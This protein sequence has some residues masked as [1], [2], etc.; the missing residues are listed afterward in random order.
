M[1]PSS[2]P[3][4]H[5]DQ[6]V[7]PWQNPVVSEMLPPELHFV[8]TSLARPRSVLPSA[9]RRLHATCTT[10]Q[11]IHIAWRNALLLWADASDSDRHAASE[12]PQ[13]S[14]LISATL[15]HLLIVNLTAQ[16][17]SNFAPTC[18]NPDPILTTRFL[19]W[20]F[21]KPFK[22][23]PSL[24]HPPARTQDAL[25]SHVSWWQPSR[26]KFTLLVYFIRAGQL[27]LLEECLVQMRKVPAPR[28]P[29][30]FWVSQQHNFD[31]RPGSHQLLSELAKTHHNDHAPFFMG[32]VALALVE[33]SLPTLLVLLRVFKDD[34][35]P[36][37]VTSLIPD[38]S[39]TQQD[40]LEMLCCL[41]PPDNPNRVI[42]LFH[43]LCATGLSFTDAYPITQYL[44]RPSLPG[45]FARLLA[46]IDLPRL[47]AISD[48][49]RASQFREKLG[50]ATVIH[51]K[52]QY[53]Q[54]LFDGALQHGLFEDHHW[55]VLLSSNVDFWLQT[56]QVHVTEASAQIMVLLYAIR[57][58]AE[59][60]YPPH[61]PDTVPKLVPILQRS[62]GIDL[63]NMIRRN[64]DCF[65][66]S[67]GAQGVLALHGAGA[68]PDPASQLSS[69]L[70][71]FSN[72]S[73]LFPACP[74]KRIGFQSAC[75]VI[76][77]LFYCASADLPHPSPSSSWSDRSQAPVQSLTPP[78]RS[79]LLLSLLTTSSLCNVTPGSHHLPSCMSTDFYLKAFELV[80]GHMT[81]TLT[82]DG[83]FQALPAPFRAYAIY[84]A[85]HMLKTKMT[86]V[87][88]KSLHKLHITTVA[89]LDPLTTAAAL[90]MSNNVRMMCALAKWICKQDQL[91]ARLSWRVIKKIQGGD[92]EVEELEQF[93]LSELVSLNQ[94]H[95][96]FN[97]KRTG[98][99]LKVMTNALVLSR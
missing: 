37:R 68:L 3:H 34:L 44:F 96:K 19:Q 13:T 54:D 47:A 92:T 32:L 5:L 11:S 63:I 4:A 84:L 83:I 39:S 46:S 66:A 40:F 51:L 65:T 79:I 87:L 24:I 88:D 61:D 23:L 76:S 94:S 67:I 56:I 48:V 97:F 86:D 36:S 42:N 82:S 16:A 75:S 77:A 22:T 64:P 10:G 41:S 98:E 81:P 49:V 90:C 2:K 89:S 45:F 21:S 78:Q 95:D 26:D 7:V 74:A 8:V 20:L 60:M 71:S 38:G 27:E 50:V 12:Q 99:M 17:L 15:K 25:R 33:W 53:D 31:T 91:C 6:S 30:S 93:M 57:L 35:T 62:M 14:P 52:E 80:I 9:S 18:P 69:I 70:T 59:G 85:C 1:S 72:P 43:W 58:A 29:W 73:S 55:S 28:L